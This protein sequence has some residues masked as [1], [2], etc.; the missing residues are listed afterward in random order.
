M[1]ATALVFPNKS[2]VRGSPSEALMPG[3]NQDVRFTYCFFVSLHNC[4][5][6]FA[7]KGLH[8]H[9]GDHVIC[10]D[11]TQCCLN[12]VSVNVILKDMLGAHT[13]RGSLAWD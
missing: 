7:P 11:L 3:K 10:W 12:R 1:V 5:S 8:T 9:L 6:S 13:A 4:F 2:E